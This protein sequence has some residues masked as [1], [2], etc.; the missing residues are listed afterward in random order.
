MSGV[1]SS[2]LNVTTFEDAAQ[3]ISTFVFNILN[4]ATRKNVAE[5]MFRVLLNI[6]NVSPPNRWPKKCLE[7]CLT[8]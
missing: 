1:V 4:V 5:E 7:L 6:L 3:K 2:I 8:S